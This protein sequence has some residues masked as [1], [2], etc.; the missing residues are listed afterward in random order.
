[1]A[2]KKNTDEI[3]SLYAAALFWDA[4][5]TAAMVEAT[6][7]ELPDADWDQAEGLAI[8]AKRKLA[9]ALAGYPRISRARAERLVHSPNGFYNLEEYAPELEGIATTGVWAE[10]TGRSA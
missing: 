3:R 5:E 6:D 8:E 10:I 9:N 2:T 4:I 1:M 7:G